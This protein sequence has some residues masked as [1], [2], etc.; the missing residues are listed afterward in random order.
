MHTARHTKSDLSNQS[1]A[2][3]SILRTLAYFDIF[4]YPLTRN[5]II[6][7]LDHEPGAS[8]V[9]ECISDL[10]QSGSVFYYQGFYSLQQN[11]L[12]VHRRRE[13]NERADKLLFK[14]LR[15]GRFLNRF[16]YVRAIGISGSLSKNFADEKADIDFFIITKSNRLWIA[17]TFMHLYKKLTFLT[18]RQR[19]YCMNYYIDEQAFML[20]DKNIYSA[21][22]I[23]TLIPVS[24]Q[25]TM[26]Q[27]F[28]INQ[29]S[30][31]YLPACSFREQSRPDT[32]DSVIKRIF[33]G[34]FSNR[35]GS[36]LDKVLFGITSRRWERKEKRNQQNEKGAVMKLITGKHF[37]RSNPGA[38]QEKVL[39]LF[40]EKTSNL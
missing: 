6:Q 9:D 26:Q 35:L 32:R 4:H 27:F 14:A 29:W 31:E 11:P 30:D 22:E 15:I 13:G 1:A 8:L 7:F 3:N 36:W 12:L 21:T 20:E 17:R 40:A 23:K 25:K 24:G 16:P 2:K 10:I 34:I 5:E 39:S 18:G 33:E 38:F 37:A 28:E 19:Y